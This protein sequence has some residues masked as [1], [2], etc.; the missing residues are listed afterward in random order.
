MTCQQEK[1]AKS[2]WKNLKNLQKD[3]IAEMN[4]G[5]AKINLFLEEKLLNDVKWIKISTDIF[6]NWKI[7]QIKAMPEGYK[8]ICVWFQL[9][10]LCGKCNESGLIILS[11]KVVA[12]DELLSN[13][14]GEDLKII[15]LSLRTFEAF[16]MIEITT[17]GVAKI[18]NWDEYQNADGLDKLREYE[19][20]RK[21]KQREKNKKLDEEKCPGHV[22]GQIWDKSRDS[23]ISISI[24]YSLSNSNILN[25]NILLDTYS[26]EYKYIL[27]N[28]ELLDTVKEWME[29]KDQKKPKAS[30]QYAE[31][32]MKGFLKKVIRESQKH[33]IENVIETISDSI[34]NNYQGVT[35]DRLEKNKKQ[36][37][38]VF[39]EWRKA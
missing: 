9:L 34:A 18:S 29:Y 19:R 27:D 10:C 31:N 22:P 36:Q 25:L 24:S 4:I 35:W 6:D 16:G 28:K 32:G 39:D 30:N 26:I 11:G 7:K 14:F 3:E 33:G 17:D 13:I 37:P 8:M 23:S 15:Q 21:A 5:N 12:N 2:V 38:S 20:V 1:H